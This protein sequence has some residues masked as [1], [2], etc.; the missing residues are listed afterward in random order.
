[1]SAVAG[2]RVPKGWLV[3]WSTCASHVSPGLAPYA[4]PERFDPSRYARGEGSAA[5]H[6]APQGPGE[7]LSSHRCGG[8]EYSTLVLLQFFTELLRA[9]AISLPEQDLTMDMSRIP[10][11]WRSGLRVRFG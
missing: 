6:F 5:H 3:V 9:P 11:N 7:A 1:M 2:R 8:V 10:A 4:S